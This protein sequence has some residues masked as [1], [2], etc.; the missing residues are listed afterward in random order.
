MLQ[1][2]FNLRVVSGLVY[3]WGHLFRPSD[4]S[5]N[6]YSPA[7]HTS[8]EL[9]DVPSGMCLQ[10]EEKAMRRELDHRYLRFHTKQSKPP[11]YTVG[12]PLLKKPPPSGNI[13]VNLP[14]VDCCAIN[15]FLCRPE[16]R[17]I[18]LVAVFVLQPNTSPL[19]PFIINSAQYCP[20]YKDY[21]QVCAYT[22]VK[23]PLKFEHVS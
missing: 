20:S 16:Y 11:S 13:E 14:E 21:F 17:G 8:V 18:R 23:R 10:R 7:P 15:S 22:G 6:L 3:S 19:I 9:S 4:R 2:T 1:A 5:Y 12:T